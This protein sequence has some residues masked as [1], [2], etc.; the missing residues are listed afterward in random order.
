MKIIDKK[1]KMSFRPSI[2]ACA[3]NDCSKKVL[4]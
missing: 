2:A 1:Q 4:P 3:F